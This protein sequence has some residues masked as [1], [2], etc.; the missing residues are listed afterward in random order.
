MRDEEDGVLGAFR[1]LWDFVSSVVTLLS[2]RRYTM[3]LLSLVLIH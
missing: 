2:H 1:F 3:L